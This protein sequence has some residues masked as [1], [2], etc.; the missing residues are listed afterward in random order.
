[1]E[2]KTTR[3]DSTTHHLSAL[4][5]LNMRKFTRYIEDSADCWNCANEGSDLCE[6]CEDEQG[7]MNYVPD[8]EWMESERKNNM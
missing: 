7:L 2:I 3:L 4:R 6:S 1:M 8:R 5:K